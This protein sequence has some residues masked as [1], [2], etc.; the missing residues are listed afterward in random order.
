MIS[1]SR[2]LEIVEYR[3]CR[4]FSSPSRT[5]NLEYA[6]A[7]K[8]LVMSTVRKRC[9][10]NGNDYYT[11]DLILHT[12]IPNGLTY[13]TNTLFIV[14]DYVVAY[15]QNDPKSESLDRILCRVTGVENHVVHAPCDNQVSAIVNQTLYLSIQQIIAPDATEVELPGEEDEDNVED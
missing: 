14:G 11:Q 7:F 10:L 8:R 3:D 12:P 6:V 4:R 5:K 1:M 15:I 2:Y 13:K 9:D